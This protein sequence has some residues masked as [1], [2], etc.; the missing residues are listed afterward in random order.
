MTEPGGKWTPYM[1]CI[2]LDKDNGA[3]AKA[4]MEFNEAIDDIATGI[5]A[6]E[7]QMTTDNV[8]AN[9]ANKVINLNGQVVREGSTSIEGLPAGIYIVNGKKYIVR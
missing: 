7:M 1:A 9:H 8:S 5:E 2:L 3:N 4:G 6:I